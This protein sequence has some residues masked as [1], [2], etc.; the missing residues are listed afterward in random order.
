MERRKIKDL[1]TI[2]GLLLFSIFS[3]I[4]VYYIGQNKNEVQ[5]EETKIEEFFEEEVE[6]VPEITD[7]S[8]EQEEKETKEVNYTFVLEIP[9]IGL[10]KGFY[11]IAHMSN[12]VNR[13]IKM[14]DKSD[15]PDVINGNVML[16]AHNGNSSVSY[17][18][19]LYKMNNGD[20]IYLY[21][22]GNKYSYKL[23]N[24]YDIEKNGKAL[25]KRDNNKSTITLITCKRNTKDKQ[26][27]YIGYLES[28]SNY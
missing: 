10:K 24:S 7:K 21:Y 8:E 14:L 6:Y 16:A 3:F 26:V 9:S 23:N 2:I 20:Y 15:Y 25:I 19:K 12:T 4:S 11:G 1:C 13:N 22:K 27:V 18:N 5:K 28:I 17:F